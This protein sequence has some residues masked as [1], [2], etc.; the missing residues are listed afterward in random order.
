D[1]PWAT[2]VS[3]I[4]IAII[5]FVGSA[6]YFRRHSGMA[7]TALL[8]RLH[9]VP[10][11]AL[12]ACGLWIV[13]VVCAIALAYFPEFFGAQL[14]QRLPV[15]DVNV[16]YASI[17]LGVGLTLL[18]AFCVEK[19]CALPLRGVAIGL[20]AMVLVSATVALLRWAYA[21]GAF[22]FDPFLPIACVLIIAFLAG[23]PVAIILALGGMLYFLI[24][25]AAPLT[26]IPSSLQYGISSF[27]LLAIPFFMIAGTLMEITGMATRLIDM[28]QEWVGHWTGGLLIAE[29]IAT[30]VFSGISGSKAAD[31]ATIGSVMKG[32]VRAYGYP[33]TEFVAVLAASAAMSE[34]VPP[35]VAMLILGSVTSLSIGALFV[36]GVVPAAIL[37]IALIVA[38]T[39]RS[40]VKGYRRG[41]SFD[42]RRALRSIP[43]ALPAL[44]VP[45]IVIGGL[46]GGIASPTESASFAVVYGFA[47]AVL[48]YRSIGRRPCLVGL[49]NATLL[50]GM[51]LL[52]VSASNLLVQAIV[53]DGLGR[54]IAATLAAVSNRQVFL[55]LSAAALIVLGF[56]LE[57]FPAILISAPIFLPVATRM[58]VDPLQ[59][60]I[61]L[62]IATGIGVMMPPVG[63]G[64]YVSCAVGEAPVNA[65]MRPSFFY[66]VFLILGLCVVILCPQLTLWLPHLL[67][68]K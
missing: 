46:V 40:R 54:T 15:L 29:V 44:G 52:M 34:T 58:G 12:A 66:N 10:R 11:D 9:G 49:R 2:D 25:D 36:A 17:W 55:F 64:F 4:L 20:A 13:L 22:A 41:P 16:G 38:I 18:A 6:A 68:M 59:F 3:T 51:V 28:V 45:V 57:G 31:I 61:L 53:I 35:S 8:D 5:A 27:I 39:I 60:G 26:V 14:G 65:A 48:V 47:V 30:Y 1:F 23:A 56:V 32:P 67:G 50:A 42:V 37:A 19:I 7:Y 21:D 33:S 24:S 63:I 62:I 43:R